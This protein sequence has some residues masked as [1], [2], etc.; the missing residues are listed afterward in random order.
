MFPR[1]TAIACTIRSIAHH[2]LRRPGGGQEDE[3]PRRPV[4]LSLRPSAYLGL[5]PHHHVGLAGL[6]LDVHLE[7]L[8]HLRRQH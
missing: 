2:R 5:R 3:G 1:A 8:P 6:H 4:S 7:R